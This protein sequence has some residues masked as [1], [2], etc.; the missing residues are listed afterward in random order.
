VGETPTGFKKT[1]TPSH[2]Q[3][4]L[5]HDTTGHLAK[6]EGWH[7][8]KQKPPP[9]H[10]GQRQEQ[11]KPKCHCQHRKNNEKNWPMELLH[12]GRNGWQ[13]LREANLPHPVQCDELAE[14]NALQRHCEN[15]L[16]HGTPEHWD[17]QNAPR[18][19]HHGHSLQLHESPWT[20][21]NEPDELQES[22]HKSQEYENL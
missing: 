17:K 2:L 11:G 10:Q 21:E 3:K 8:Q 6:M 7:C 14:W 16:A 20:D 4:H 12:Q 9:E 15:D 18:H 13:S 22:L 1:E 19:P 5:G